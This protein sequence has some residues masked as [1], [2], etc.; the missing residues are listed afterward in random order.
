MAAIL[1]ILTG[2]FDRP[3]GVMTSSPVAGRIEDGEPGGKG[4][5]TGRWASRVNGHPE[6]NGEF[7]AASLADE[8]ETEGPGQLR[9]ALTIATMAAM[10]VGTVGAKAVATMAA[11]LNMFEEVGVADRAARAG[12]RQ[13]RQAAARQPVVA[14][15]VH[16]RRLAV[17]RGHQPAGGRVDRGVL[18]ATSYPME[19]VEASRRCAERRAYEERRKGPSGRQ[20]A[21]LELSSSTPRR[22]PPRR[23][24]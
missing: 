6:V 16:H 21:V 9:A 23:R 24:A 12:R 5:R 8:M 1:N 19:D 11:A 3:G 15:L 10:T 14:G 13:R 17:D 2:N 22:S 4:Y 7:P 20:R 18:T